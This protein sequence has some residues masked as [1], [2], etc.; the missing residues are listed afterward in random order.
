MNKNPM[1]KNTSGNERDHFGV[2]N[3]VIPLNV[4]RNEFIKHCLNTSTVT[5]ITQNE[6]IN[7]VDVS[8]QLIDK[9]DFPEQSTSTK[10][11]LGSL[12]LF[13]NEMN[14][15]QPIIIC[16]LNKNDKFIPDLKENE[17][18]TF[19]QS[20]DYLTT[21]N[22]TLQ[23]EQ[24][25]VYLNLNSLNKETNFIINVNGFPKGNFTCN[26]HGDIIFNSDLFNVRTT[27]GFKLA[28]KNPV[29][30][31][32]ESNI[33]YK[34]GS[35]LSYIDEFD[36]ALNFSKN[37]FNVKSENTAI[38]TDKLTIANGT[39]P[40]LLGNDT[41][42]LINKL[43][44]ACEKITVASFGTPPVNI[45]EFTLL[46]LELETLKSSIVFIK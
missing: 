32:K 28:T 1:L 22:E 41:I 38:D 39:Q 35:G 7:N 24:G 33:E 45:A 17:L 26:T 9:L 2:G 40:V 4:D 8:A 14:H 37:N 3:I 42:D 25:T 21:I 29:K 18:R 43:I 11:N 27:E 46:K 20:N 16:T 30:G 44:S 12:V 15:N 31:S 19:A 23:P 6:I 10:L 34:V 36:N 5:I 13:V